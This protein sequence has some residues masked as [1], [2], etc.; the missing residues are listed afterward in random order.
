MAK[1]R[2]SPTPDTPVARNLDALL[3]A[4]GREAKEVSVAAGL[5][6]TACRDILNGRS[7]AP[8]H[9]TLEA[10]AAELGVAV[11]ELLSV[12][13]P[14]AAPRADT[15]G[16][17]VLATTPDQGGDTQPALDVISAFSLV[18]PGQ[19]F[20]LFAPDDA[21][22]PR[23]HR[24]EPILVHRHRPARD[25]QLA[26]VSLGDGRV[27]VRRVRFEDDTLHTESLTPAG[28]EQFER[29]AVKAVYQVAGIVPL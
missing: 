22:A 1:P 25:G 12:D 9:S 10:I 5:S 7:R 15:T 27:L 13:A 28:A 2:T 16:V 17:P 6:E 26:V 18:A 19:V 14:P 11:Y 20:A 4:K 23:V 24:G 21:M 8:R 29:G 3:R